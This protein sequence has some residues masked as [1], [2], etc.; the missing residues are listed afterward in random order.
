[1]RRYCLVSREVKAKIRSIVIIKRK[2]PI[3]YH[4]NYTIQ[5]KYICS[6]TAAMTCRLK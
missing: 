6:V 4:I 1:M 5:Q 2:I 3:P